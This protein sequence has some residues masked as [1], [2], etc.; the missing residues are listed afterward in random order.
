MMLLP[1]QH[2]TASSEDY[3]PLCEQVHMEYTGQIADHDI[4]VSDSTTTAG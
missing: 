4:M 3:A 2:L 1:V